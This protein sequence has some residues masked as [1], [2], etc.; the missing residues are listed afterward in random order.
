MNAEY[1]I[2]KCSG[3]RALLMKDSRK[4]TRQPDAWMLAGRKML[5]SLRF[6]PEKDSYLIHFQEWGITSH[7]Q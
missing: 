2:S 6:I 7:Q 4:N 5:N 1:R 3:Y